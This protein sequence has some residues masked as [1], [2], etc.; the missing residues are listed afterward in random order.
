MD[1]LSFM[2]SLKPYLILCRLNVSLFA[3][4]SAATGFFLAPYHRVVDA[5]IPSA[6]VFLLAGGASALNQYQERDIDAKMERTRRRPIPTGL[7]P[8]GQ[9]LALSLVLMISGLVALVLSG[10][11]KASVLGALAV[12][13]Y[14]GIYTSLKK[15]TAFAAVPG[16]AVGM[17][18]PAIG[19][20]SAGGRLFDP[21][22][23][24]LCALFFLWQIPHFWL[25]LLNHG[26]EY[27]QAGLPSLTRVMSKPQIGRVTF[28]WIFAAAI[29]GLSLPLYGSIRS[30][31]SA[32]L[33][34]PCAGWIIWSGRMLSGSGQAGPL[35][36]GLF[37]KINIY[38]FLIMSLLSLE[39]I[40]FRRP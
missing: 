28:S 24:A 23:L 20:V 30:P 7:I 4:A 13:W 19:W 8:P 12:F 15:T 39:N 2:S 25:L 22:L 29:A 18:P 14:N 36:P 35:A 31:V 38:L 1:K 32:L 6:A 40:F 26:D 10:G 3:A 9:A 16:A 37:K 34:I 11:V 21:M 33:L 27:E 5:L 17:V